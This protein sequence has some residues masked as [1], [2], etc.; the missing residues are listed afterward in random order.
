M[1]PSCLD[2]AYERHAILQ[3]LN[4]NP[5]FPENKAFLS[6]WGQPLP[7]VNTKPIIHKL[8]IDDVNSRLEFGTKK[9]G[10]GLQPFNGRDALKDAYEEALD[11]CNYLRQ[12]I[13]ERDGK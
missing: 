1:K 12:S 2:A 4:R 10:T 7:E 8:V 5:V 11:L 3:G 6:K 9:Y 13:Y